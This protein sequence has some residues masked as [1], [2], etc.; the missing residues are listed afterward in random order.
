MQLYNSMTDHDIDG[1][2][3]AHVHMHAYT[4][5]TQITIQMQQINCVDKNKKKIKKKDSIIPTV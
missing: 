5:G 1:N 4:L 2:R 3:S